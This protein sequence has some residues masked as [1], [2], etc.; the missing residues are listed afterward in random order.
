MKL[1]AYA[2]HDTRNNLQHFWGDRFNPLDTGF[3]FYSLGLC[4]LATSRNTGCMD[5]NEIF[6]LWIQE[7]ISYTVSG[8]RRLFHA[9]QTRRGGGLHYR[10][11]S[12]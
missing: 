11:A 7:A 9:L 2:G 3:L 12:C 4:L 1:S 5:I 6:R 10:S 8:L